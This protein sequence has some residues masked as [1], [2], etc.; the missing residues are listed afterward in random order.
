[1]CVCGKRTSVLKEYIT[2]KYHDCVAGWAGIK[3]VSR[4]AGMPGMPGMPE[5]QNASGFADL[6]FSGLP[7]VVTIFLLD[8]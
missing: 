2:K 3:P 7:F 1:M 4:N 8:Y 6:C 5:C